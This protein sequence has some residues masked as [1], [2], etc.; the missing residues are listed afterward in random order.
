[1][2]NQWSLLKNQINAEMDAQGV[3]KADL[4]R[5]LK[6]P[7]PHVTRYLGEDAQ[8]P[9]LDKIAEISEALNIPLNELYKRAIESHARKAG[10]HMVATP[11]RDTM[12]V[13]LICE[14][15][16]MSPEEIQSIANTLRMMKEKRSATKG[17][18]AKKS[19]QAG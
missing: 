2:G 7:P 16:S 13:K 10:P 12:L 1:M 3:T 15:C 8:E 5:R 19:N 17:S 14:L 9:G 4:A 11:P 18:S 6:W